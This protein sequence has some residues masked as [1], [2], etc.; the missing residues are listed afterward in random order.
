MEKVL[1]VDDNNLFR[2]MLRDVLHS[3]L[4]MEFEMT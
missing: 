3:K 4:P 1:I 2:N